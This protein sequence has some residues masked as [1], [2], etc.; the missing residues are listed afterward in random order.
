MTLFTL[1]ANM[2]KGVVTPYVHAR[3]DTE[4]YQ[5][6]LAEGLNIVGLRYGGF[7]RAPG[8]VLA[9]ETK[10][11]DKHSRFIPFKFNRVQ[12]YAI[13]AGDLYMRF[14]IRLPVGAAQVQVASAAYEIATP[15][16]AAQVDDIKVAQSGDVL[17][18]T[19]DGVEPQTLTRNSE[20]DWVLAP[21]DPKDGPYLD[22]NISATNVTPAEYGSI[23]PTMTS[24][25]APSG[26]VTDSNSQADAWRVFNRQVGSGE[27]YSINLSGWI[28]YEPTTP[29]VV[30][31]FTIQAIIDEQGRTPST[32]TVKGWD[33]AAFV[34]LDSRS[35]QTGFEGGEVR[36]FKFT[37]ETAYERYRFEWTSIGAESSSVGFIQNID[38]HEAADSQT[39]F[40]L[41]AS[42]IA[43]VNDGVGFLASDVGRPIRILDSRGG[44]RWCEIKARTSTTVVDIVLHDAVMT[45]LDSIVSW[46]LGAWSASVGWPKTIALYEDRL[47]FGGSDSNPIGGEATVTSD[48]DNFRVSAPLVSDDGISYKMTGGTLNPVTWM[49]PVRD[50]LIGTEG[51]LRAVGRNNNSQGFGPDNIRQRSET[52]VS[53]S[54]KDPLGIGNR[55]VFLNG[56]NTR[57]YEAIFTYESEG[58]VARELSTLNEH[59][60][61][62]GDGALEIQYQSTPHRVI[63]ARKADGTLVAA[64]YDPDQKVFGA[65]PVDYG[66]EVESVLALP[67]V[68]RTDVFMVVKRTVNGATKRYVETLAEFWREGF[69]EQE[70]PIYGTCSS[71]YEGVA[72]NTLTGLDQFEGKTVSVWTD[73]YSLDDLGPVTGGSL[74]LPDPFTTTK[75]VVGEKIPWNACTLR[76]TT[77]GNRDGS[78][79]GRKAQIV[80]A[81]LDIYQSAGV[82]IGSKSKTDL[83][84]FDDGRRS[85]D[86]PE[87]KTGMFPMT[88]D[89]SWKNNGQGVIEGDTMLP[90]TIRAVTLEL[91]G[92]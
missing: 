9:G 41:T 80:N 22:I 27:W 34:T 73:G 38:F 23:V 12:T 40:S 71:I 85:V 46:R 1:Q 61:G 87:L 37:N 35:G 52:E 20:T 67:G 32:W 70:I 82:K 19:C 50:L 79:I 84:V 3:V 62:S 47:N 59:L 51:S 11:N 54:D 90:A 21:Y 43:G 36:S 25:T 72:T 63:W 65:T 44:W 5:S 53:T 16:T 48:Y 28:D 75:A 17:Y 74:T 66:G 8:T 33:G 29:R 92:E 10:H 69:G 86:A 45:N 7:T 26:V 18:L 4:H 64:T 42:S 57:L 89:D 58:Y 78:G 2:T 60:F 49:L 6:S 30:D 81:Y 91:D 39:P 76:I 15:Y 56:D 83:M 55:V 68:R 13:E 14:W 77:W 88:V 31:G 24:L